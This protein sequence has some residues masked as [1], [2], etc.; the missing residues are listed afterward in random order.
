[1][2]KTYIWKKPDRDLYELLDQGCYEEVVDHSTVNQDD[3]LV[4]WAENDIP[5][6]RLSLKFGNAILQDFSRKIAG[7]EMAYAI[8][9]TGV[10]LGTVECLEYIFRI[11]TRIDK[12][13]HK[14]GDKKLVLFYKQIGRRKPMIRKL[15]HYQTCQI[16]GDKGTSY[17]LKLS[18]DASGI[19]L[20]LGCLR[21][22]VRKLS[23]SENYRKE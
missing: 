16:C 17:N 22:F 2:K 13:P 15:K 10:L 19:I 3:L 12:L 9:K 6:L 4:K 21:R 8:F 5:D 1:M 20:C 18:R 7:D 14:I 23:D 11:K